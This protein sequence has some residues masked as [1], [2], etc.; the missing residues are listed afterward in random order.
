MYQ[1]L[2]AL[3]GKQ[4]IR[5]DTDDQ[6]PEIFDHGCDA[7]S[8]LL[9]FISAGSC[10]GINHLPHLAVT[11]AA[12]QVVIFYFYHWQCYVSGKVVFKRCYTSH[13]LLLLLVTICIV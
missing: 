13:K 3:D 5:T 4:C 12:S 7:V 9:L 6:L 2:D 8:N 10:V 11:M 1:T